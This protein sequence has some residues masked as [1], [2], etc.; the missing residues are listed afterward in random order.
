MSR[1]AQ[2]KPLDRCLNPVRVWCDGVYSSFPCGRCAACSLDKANN[3]SLRLQDEIEGTPYSIFFTLT[4][5]N[6]YVPK[7][8]F[9]YDS[10]GCSYYKPIE[11]NIRFNGVEDVR[12]DD[13]F[14]LS[15]K[16]KDFRLQNFSD[17]NCIGYASK[18]DIQLWL[19]LL[20]K[21][22]NLYFN[23]L[24]EDGKEK[25]SRYRFR[26]YI[27]SEYG[28][29]THRPHYHGLLF[30]N[31]REAAEFSLQV[32]M[33][34]NWQMCDKSLF[35]E[36]THFA[37]AGAAQYVTNYVTGYNSLPSI[38]KCPEIRPFRLASKSPAIGFVSFDKSQ[39]FEGLFAGVNEYH[40]S[41]SR[42]EAE[43]IFQYPASYCRRLFPK[44]REY[45]LASYQRLHYVYGFIYR[46][47]VERRFDFDRV[48]RFLRQKWFVADYTASL[49]CYKICIEYG[50][51][52]D[53]YLYL[54]DMYYYKEQM[55]SLKR[56]Y[57]WQENQKDIYI[58]IRSYFNF[59]SLCKFYMTSSPHSRFYFDVWC[60]NFG[61]DAF[62][63]C[64]NL[65][66]D[67]LFFND[68][69]KNLFSL[70]VD[71][72]LRDSIKLPKYNEIVGCAPH[73]V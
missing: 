27:I 47:V 2:H 72:I 57:E 5:N 22:I 15:V 1:F 53:T 35:D 63:F 70:E 36:H 68:S 24:D 58:I 54:L 23:N 62:E 61:F 10:L 7:M 46:Q 18:R 31:N 16:S 44:I 59:E 64:S 37:D 19:K 28:P 25:S 8:S 69:E 71:D 11:D 26:Y 9:S 67:D 29:T 45:R 60:S 55:S 52:V 51:D 48:T 43:Y 50:F 21:D 73:I 14:I 66:D 33:F 30:F 3:W 34:K 40:K 38:F 41:V 56:F 42:I 65:K 17:I 49:T 39:I 6:K 12:R 20:R 32:S 13:D 4:Y